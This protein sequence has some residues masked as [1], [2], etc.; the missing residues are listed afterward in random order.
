MF[1]LLFLIGLNKNMKIARFF[2]FFLAFALVSARSFAQKNAISGTILDEKKQ[3]LV[4]VSVYLEGTIRGV[5]SDRSGAYSL[6]DIPAGSYQLVVSAVSFQK[7]IQDI[8]LSSGTKQEVDV[9][10][11]DA[12]AKLGEVSNCASRGIK[13]QGDLLLLAD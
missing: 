12:A 2:F 11:H 8:N 7:F 10:L 9:V 3:P 13:G 4:G 5:Q 6:K 1:V